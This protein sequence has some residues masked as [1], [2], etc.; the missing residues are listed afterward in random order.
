VA[1]LKAHGVDPHWRKDSYNDH[2][3]D[4]QHRFREISGWQVGTG[5]AL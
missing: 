5:T 1:V 2:T 4:C 3:A